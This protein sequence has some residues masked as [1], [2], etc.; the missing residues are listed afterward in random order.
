LKK[1]SLHYFQINVTPANVAE[2][3]PAADLFLI[4][5]VKD[6]CCAFLKKQ[7]TPKSSIGIREYAR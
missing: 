7:L 2:L 5:Y 3:L 4:S 6:K 1:F